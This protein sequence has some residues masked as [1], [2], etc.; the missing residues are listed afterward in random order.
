M[1]PSSSWQHDEEQ[2]SKYTLSDAKRTLNLFI[3]QFFE[4]ICGNKMPTR[5]NRG[6]YC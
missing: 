4:V 2:Q 5:C 1:L 6:Y 3:S